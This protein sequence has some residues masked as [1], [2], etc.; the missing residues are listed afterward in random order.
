MAL[1]ADTRRAA[2]PDQIGA[3][4]TP[5]I[6]HFCVVLLQAA[7]LS[8]P[9]PRMGDAV[10]LLAII[11]A[12]GMAYVTI[13]T[14]RADRQEGYVPVFEDW[15]FHVIL[16]FASYTMMLIGS[17]VLLSNA[18]AALF[19]LGTVALVLM[20]SGIHNAWDTVTFLVTNPVNP[21]KDADH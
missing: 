7:I 15:L 6:V 11:G 21:T 4:G 17:I 2:N 1:V 3:F 13:V 18:T 14:R 16:P 20:F 5:N 10:I 8:A 9:W 12:A 19:I